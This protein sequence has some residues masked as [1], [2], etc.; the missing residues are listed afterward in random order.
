VP[1]GALATAVGRA[2]TIVIGGYD[3]SRVL[4]SVEALTPG[5]VDVRDEDSDGGDLPALRCEDRQARAQ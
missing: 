3:G 5:R 4:G 1:R 2:G